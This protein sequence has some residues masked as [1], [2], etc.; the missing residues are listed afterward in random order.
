MCVAESLFWNHQEKK[1]KFTCQ[2]RGLTAE[3]NGH[4]CGPG[5]SIIMTFCKKFNRR[6][7]M[8]VLSN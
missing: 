4:S 1:N 7:L 3:Q 8:G 5:K 2:V 6:S